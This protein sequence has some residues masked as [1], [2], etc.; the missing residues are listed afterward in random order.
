[1]HFRGWQWTEPEK[2]QRLNG[3]CVWQARTSLLLSVLFWACF[4]MLML[5][6][7]SF[8]AGFFYILILASLVMQWLESLAEPLS[9]VPHTFLPAS[10]SPFPVLPPSLALYLYWRLAVYQAFRSAPL[11]KH[12]ESSL[13][14]SKYLLSGSVFLNRAENNGFASEVQTIVPIPPFW[15]HQHSNFQNGVGN[16]RGLAFLVAINHIID[17][18]V[19]FRAKMIPQ[20]HLISLN[21]KVRHSCWNWFLVSCTFWAHCSN[22][23]Q[24]EVENTH[25]FC[26]VSHPV[27]T[28]K[29]CQWQCVTS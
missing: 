9:L 22:S 3:A 5:V 2:C 14:M 20:M 26:F 24:A 11:P 29:R 8:A 21:S 15:K 18:R 12:L 7:R 4:I 10:E 1:M 27:S 13:N 25:G 19:I 6:G 28:S 17:K 23:T 16:E